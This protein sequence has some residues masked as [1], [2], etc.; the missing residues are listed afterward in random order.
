MKLVGIQVTQAQSET[1]EVQRLK[2]R[3]V[4]MEVTG[5]CVTLGDAPNPTPEGV[6]GEINRALDALE[7][8]DYEDLDF[9]DRTLLP[10]PHEG[11]ADV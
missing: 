8:G 11:K 10:M 9:G 6:C 1:T 5:F 3:L 2:A 4:E 7:A